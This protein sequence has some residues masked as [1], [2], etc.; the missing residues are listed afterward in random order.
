MEVA[1]ADQSRWM[2]HHHAVLNGQHPDSHHHSLSH[3]YMEPMAP[4]LPQDEVDMFLNHLD[5]Q[6]NPYYT[7]S[8]A[9]VTYSQAHARLAGNQ[10]CRPHLIHSPGIPW[11][12]PGKAALSAAH[13][14][15]AWAVSH[16][17]KQGLH[18]SSSGYPCSSST[19]PVSSPN[20]VSHSSAHLYSFPPTP[21]KDVSPDPGATSPTSSSTRMEEKE[22]IKYQV[23][24]SDGMKMESCSP[25]R[26]GLMNGQGPA[27]HHPIPTYPAYPLHSTH[28][29]GGSLFHPGSLLGGSNS[30]FTPK[31]KSKAR[32]T[33]EGR[34]CVN[35]GATSTPLWRRDG[36]GHY[37][38]QRLWTVPQDER[39]EQT[40]HQTQTRAGTCCANCQTTITTL[41]RR[42][43]NGDPVCNACGL[44]YK[45]HNVNRPMTMKKEGIQTRN[46]KMSSKSKRG[47][48]P[49]DGFDE[50]SKCMQD[51]AS[52][53]GGGPGLPSHMTHMGH[54]TPFSHSGHMLPTPTPIHP[55][56]GHHPHH[57]NRSPVWA[58][59]LSH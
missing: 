13:H 30:S 14:H 43:G 34:E 51:K 27:T 12:D 45:L 31:C 32:S 46:R 4:L 22:S 59:P 19:A 11:L 42:N 9:R 20:S 36:T 21:P 41:W 29:Y 40:S 7:N 16:F 38:V 57:S 52:H 55:S 6:G 15:N 47:K 39:P 2:A 8:R 54:L 48:R 1:A 50:L 10:V 28:E 26:S 37:S 56:F 58:E 24:L 17:S 49:G 35:C 5:S 18:P 3:N 25:L 23:H 44:Y 53:F 33:S